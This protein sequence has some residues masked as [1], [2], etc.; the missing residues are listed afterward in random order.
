MKFGQLIKSW[1]TFLLKNY[2]QNVMGEASSR[3][4]SEK[5]KLSIPPD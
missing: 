4:F 1:E 3:P 2:T 5:L